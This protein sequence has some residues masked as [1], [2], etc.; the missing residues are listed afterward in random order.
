GLKQAFEL[1]DETLLQLRRTL[2][3]AKQQL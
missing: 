3:E 2:G 1:N